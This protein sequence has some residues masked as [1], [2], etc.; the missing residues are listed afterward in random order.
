MN[1]LDVLSDIRVDK[2]LQRQLLVGL[3]G[4]AGLL[5]QRLPVP[6]LQCRA[7]EGLVVGTKQVA[8]K[9]GWVGLLQRPGI[10]LCRSGKALNQKKFAPSRA[11]P[12]LNDASVS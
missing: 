10:A 9:R 7:G 3:D 8:I 12:S 6:R 4:A 1:C 11:Q 2:L 5:A